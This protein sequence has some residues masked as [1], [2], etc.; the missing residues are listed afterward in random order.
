MKKNVVLGVT[1]GIA[2]Y[3]SAEI[4][5]RLK[6]LDV[7]VDIIMTKHA[8][9]FITPLTF[10]SLSGNK[11]VVDMFD[12]NFMPDIEH[13]SLAKKADVLLIAPA[14]ANVIAKLA[15][16]LADDMLTTVALASKAQL[17]IAPAMN[18]VMY[19]AEVTQKNMDILRDRG[20]IIIEPLEGLLACNDI[21]KGKME[22]PEHIVEITMHYLMKQTD[23]LGKK[24]LLTA[25]PTRETIDPVRYI[26]NHSTGK[27][28]YAMA[29]EAARR[30]AEVTLI[31]GKV[32]LKAPY[33]VKIISVESAQEMYE[34]VMD[35]ASE[36]DIIIKSAAVA[37]YTPKNKSDQKIKKQPGDMKI[38]LD[39]TKDIL[40]EIGKIKRK[41]QI[42][43]GFA[44]E[45]DDLIENAKSKMQ[46]K[47]L[48][49]IVANDVKK[50]GAGF[51]VDTNIVTIIEKDGKIEY[52]PKMTKA[53][54]AK[55][56]LDIISEK[57]NQGKSTN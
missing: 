39:R 32:S 1:G 53:G 52:L 15:Y 13:I 27:M 49:L 20:A 10:Q 35:R 16:G 48:D 43:V 7:N 12:L 41:D 46:R 44:A 56:V 37:D 19:E 47:N 21:G 42:L 14:T 38:E 30:G 18:S 5:S 33:G 51:G 26:T 8:Q 55:S 11:T 54:V 36:S 2:A 28:G 29:A 22:E 24:I 40:F 6:K 3:K 34:Q 50:E 17:I 25:G 45:T 9:E 23:L 31:S 57:L 4:V